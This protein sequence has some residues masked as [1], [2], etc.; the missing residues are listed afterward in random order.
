MFKHILLPTD[1]TQ[2]S[3]KAVEHGLALAK[4]VGAEASILMATRM[5]SPKDMKEQATLGDLHPIDDYENRLEM[6]ATEA[7][8][9]CKGLADRFGVRWVPVCW[10]C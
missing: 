9:H 8:A 5:W 2:L 7:L 1:G 3:F 4:S 10:A 6:V